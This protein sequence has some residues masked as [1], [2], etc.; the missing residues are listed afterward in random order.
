MGLTLV[1]LG[2]K[3]QERLL[4]LLVRETLIAFIF[5]FYDYILADW[6]F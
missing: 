6:A 3:P 5:F 1:H 2:L 4:R